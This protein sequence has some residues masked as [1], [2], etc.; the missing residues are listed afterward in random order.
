MFDVT[1]SA[2]ALVVLAPGLLLIGLLIWFEGGG[3]ILFRQRRTGFGGAPFVIYKFRTMRT[4]DDGEV[5]NS[6]VR[7]D[8]RI[9]PL[10]RILRRTSLDELP[11]LLNVFRGEMSMVGPRPHALAHDRF[12]ETCVDQYNDRFLVRPGITGLAQI[13]GYRGEIRT[14][15]CMVGRVACDIS[16]IRRWTPMLDLKIFIKTLAVGLFDPAAY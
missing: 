2:A 14:I 7:H 6:A 4:M 5:V 15:E 11:Q 3:P 13:S 16:Y 9:T 12:Y 1:L 8:C 10:G